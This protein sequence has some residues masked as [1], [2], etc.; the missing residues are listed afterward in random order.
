MCPKIGPRS[1]TWPPCRPDG[2]TPTANLRHRDKDPSSS[3]IHH[4]DRM[5]SE[6]G[7]LMRRRTGAVLLL[8]ALACVALPGAAFADTKDAAAA[9]ALPDSVAINSIWV[10]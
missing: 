8:A 10:V 4:V 3:R 9:G 7:G 2:E 6:R 5:V 1:S